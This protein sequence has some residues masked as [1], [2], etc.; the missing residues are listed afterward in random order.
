MKKIVK[1]RVIFL[2]LTLALT[3]TI[4]SRANAQ[5]TTYPIR[6]LTLNTLGKTL[7]LDGE[8]ADRDGALTEFSDGKAIKNW[9]VKYEHKGSSRGMC[10]PPVLN[11]T[12]DKTDSKGK[13][14]ELFTGLSTFDGYSKLQYQKIRLIPDCD[15]WN[16]YFIGDGDTGFSG[17]LNVA[18]R[19]YIVY[20]IFR[21]FGIP[22][23]DI[24]GFTDITFITPDSGYAGRS[25]RYMIVQRLTE[26]DD[27]IPFTKQFNF[28]SKLY[29]SGEY[30]SSNRLWD[31]K[32][33][34]R[35]ISATLTNN[36][37]K[38]PLTL[39][40]D[41]DT[42]IRFLLLSDFLN[43]GDMAPLHNEDWGIDLTTGK[44]KIIPHG[45]DSS[46]YCASDGTP[47]SYLTSLIDNLS[48]ELRASYEVAYYRIAQ[49]IFNK[50]VSL[51]QMMTLVDQFPRKD[52]DKQKLI[53]Y[54]RLRFYK[55]ATY[56]NSSA[57]AAELRQPHQ[58]QQLTL[59]FSSEREYQTRNQDFAKTCNKTKTALSGVS[60]E[61]IGDL[62]LAYIP[63]NNPPD[64]CPDGYVCE[65]K[66]V[67]SAKNGQVKAIIEVRTSDLALQMLKSQY[68]KP[69]EVSLV[70]K[71]N[72]VN[73]IDF[74]V[75]PLSGNVEDFAG[76]YY[77]IP[78][79]S[80]VRFSLNATI[81]SNQ[82]MK[83]SYYFIL[84]SFQPNNHTLPQILNVKSDNL[85]LGSVEPMK[86]VAPKRG[87]ALL[88]GEEYKITWSGSPNRP[89]QI[90][91]YST[92]GSQTYVSNPAKWWTTYEN[93]EYAWTIGKVYEYEYDEKNPDSSWKQ[94]TLEPG[95]Y[96]L[97]IQDNM[98]GDIRTE[99]GY[100]TI[101]PS[102]N[103]IA[104]AA[105]M[106]EP[107]TLLLNYDPSGGESE[108]VSTFKVMISAGNHD[109]KISKS[110]AF[111]SYL[112][113]KAGY[114]IYDGIQHYDPGSGTISDE[115]DYYTIPAGTKSTFTVRTVF[116]PQRMLAGV[117]RGVL[118]Q[119]RLGDN[120]NSNWIG[121]P[122]PNTTNTVVVIGE[123]SPYINSSLVIPTVSD[124]II[125]LYG[126]RFA[127]ATTTSTIMLKQYSEDCYIDNPL[128]VTPTY[129]FRSTSPT[130]TSLRFKANLPAGT[131]RVQVSDPKT[132]DSNYIDITIADPV[133]ERAGGNSGGLAAKVFAGAKQT[134]TG[135]VNRVS[136]LVGIPVQTPSLSTGSR[137]ATP[138]PSPS[139]SSASRNS[140]AVQTPTPTPRMTT[141]PTPTNSSIPTPSQT[142]TPTPTP[143][144]SNTPTPTP[145]TTNTPT[146]TPSPSNSSTPTPTPYPTVTPTLSPTPTV[147]PTPNYSPVPT[148]S[149][150]PTPYQTNTPTPIPTSA[151]TPSPTP[152]ASGSPAAYY[153]N[154]DMTAS[155][156]RAI[157]VLI[158]RF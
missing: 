48:A 79:N 121:V 33:I 112:L 124:D 9:K 115:K 51:D 24:V 1:T 34:D 107:P 155:I 27:Q 88:A 56:F 31:I 140:S 141:S 16:D 102:A 77:V 96:N 154:F 145:F 116:T 3:L 138:S 53:E 146:P 43:V 6:S 82:V 97:R 25:F 100:F 72:T 104:P 120:S 7:L 38:S 109:Q 136:S 135:L 108:L 41:P 55:Y 78:P 83:D 132:G 32:T 156:L 151:P 105:S 57:F 149:P 86:M 66:P 91:I 49:E 85:D 89:V 52:V 22:T 44:A 137:Q 21:K 50:S 73:H 26:Q 29:E 133:S 76:P 61:V 80:T 130:G 35:L 19:E 39:S 110:W 75:N 129:Q 118:N 23:A 131:Y 70:G 65:G 46:F 10:S 45:F 74:H 68:G 128:C 153:G 113:S 47:G 8:Q 150:T 36:T 92:N 142:T 15:I 58:P 59:P 143:Y 20:K 122:E 30:E 81:D 117:Y 11:F 152:T 63:G 158:L 40:F 12:F 123:R 99:S 157:G 139:P 67:E 111:S 87:E 17:Q 95:Q 5:T 62:S 42:T 125:I 14:R 2:V 54:L 84:N 148:L 94:I 90:F 144:Q 119:I 106:L 127:S 93:N 60:V 37:N 13:A 147:T 101:S 114:A 126:T 98:I 64:K 18:L 134:Y 69:F 28:N 71:E 4:I 103:H